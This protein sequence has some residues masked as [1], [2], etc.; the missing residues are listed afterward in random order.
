MVDFGLQLLIL[1]VDLPN[2]FL[3]VEHEL[4]Q[5]VVRFEGL[6]EAQADTPYLFA[7]RGP[8][9]T[10]MLCMTCDF[11]LRKNAQRITICT[12]SSVSGCLFS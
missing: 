6:S 7:L 10:F 8:S 4:V 1:E 2:D 9:T 11:S 3:Q 5:C 12:L